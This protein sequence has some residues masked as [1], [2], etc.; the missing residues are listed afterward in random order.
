MRHI[1]M[2]GFYAGRLVC[3]LPRDQIAAGDTSAH[4]PY[5]IPADKLDQ[6][7][8]DTCP[9]CL[10]EWDAAAPDDENEDF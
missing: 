4:W 3:G 2:T 8:A 1:S 5:T 7:R 6:Y 10:A 9:A